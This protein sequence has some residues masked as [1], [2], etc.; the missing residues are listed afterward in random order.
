MF[1]K[2]STNGINFDNTS[3]YEINEWL[4][5]MSE[6]R[7]KQIMIYSLDRQTP[8]STLQKI[9]RTTLDS[10]AELARSKGFD[11]LAV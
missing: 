1:I 6:I 2:G 5:A 7:P 4:K 9:D 10:I 3:D 8:I 11:V